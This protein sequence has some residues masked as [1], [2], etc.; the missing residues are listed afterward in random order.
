MVFIKHTHT[1]AV[2]RAASY[3]HKQPC[4]VEYS[5]NVQHTNNPTKAF[6]SRPLSVEH[7][8]HPDTE[9]AHTQLNL[10]QIVNNQ[11]ALYAVNMN[12]KLKQ[13]TNTGAFTMHSTH[14]NR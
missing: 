10:P 14:C 12:V 7:Q 6:Q 3:A 8:Q 5:D 1:C 4:H 2:T 13:F 11:N 9:K